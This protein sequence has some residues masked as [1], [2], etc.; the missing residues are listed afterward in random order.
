MSVIR[1]VKGV[2]GSREIR[3]GEAEARRLLRG[4]TAGRFH[5]PKAIKVDARNGRS[6]F[7]V[8]ERGSNERYILKI[9]AA[10]SATAF[11]QEFRFIGRM[12][13]N[14]AGSE[15]FFVPEP[16]VFLETGPAMVITEAPGQSFR[17]RLNSAN[18]EERRRDLQRVGA[19]LY[20]FK[21]AVGARA[22]PFVAE[23]S[24]ER[25]VRRH[26]K[27]Q[28]HDPDAFRLALDRL[29][30]M[31]RPLDGLKVP[32][33]ICHGDF[34]PGNVLL[35][36]DRVTGIDFGRR[37]RSYAHR[38]LSRMLVFAA[39]TT[40]AHDWSEK[41]ARGTFGSDRDWILEGFGELPAPMVDAA[42][43]EAALLIWCN[44]GRTEKTSAKDLAR[45]QRLRSLIAS[46][47]G[48]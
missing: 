29:A 33:G 18:V 13:A 17:E 2:V 12:A 42:L 10:K 45:Y 34:H 5:S 19:W 26:A 4:G 39:L 11:A 22:R 36:P 16:V 41:I 30:Q 7:R 31:M 14:L 1:L 44:V 9:D 8:R 23:R 43:L 6:V 40:E 37:A 25:I 3:A 24:I 21:G 47:E 38:D 27:L 20:A 28:I 15:E 46:L 35:S 32:S 48:M